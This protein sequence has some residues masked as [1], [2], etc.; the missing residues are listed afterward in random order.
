[1]TVTFPRKIPR[2]RG[3]TPSRGSFAVVNWPRDTFVAETERGIV[4]LQRQL[5]QREQELNKERNLRKQ[6]EKQF[7]RK[8][9]DYQRKFGNGGTTKGMPKQYAYFWIISS[10]VARKG[11]TFVFI[12]FQITVERLNSEFISINHRALWLSWST[13]YQNLLYGSSCDM[14]VSSLR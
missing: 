5:Q 8:S 4:L 6:L 12:S 9:A 2:W 10:L 7:E 3:L 14:S 11:S 13:H 1:M